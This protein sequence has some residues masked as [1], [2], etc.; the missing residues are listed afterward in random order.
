MKSHTKTTLEF[1]ATTMLTVVVFVFLVGLM[2]LCAVFCHTT[3]S[4]T[5]NQNDSNPEVVFLP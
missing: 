1:V 3:D 4:P 2:L 5:T